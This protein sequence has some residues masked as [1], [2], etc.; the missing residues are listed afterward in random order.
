MDDLVPAMLRIAKDQ[1]SRGLKG[2]V[3]VPQI[4][5][6]LLDWTCCEFSYLARQ[7]SQDFS[8]SSAYDGIDRDP[9]A[10]VQGGLGLV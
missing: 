1:R 3:P 6:L 7:A 10:R 9:A 4:A 5:L 2:V 8:L